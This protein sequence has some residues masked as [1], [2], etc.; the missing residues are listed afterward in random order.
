MPNAMT[1]TPPVSATEQ[2]PYPPC[3]QETPL[4]AFQ[5]WGINAVRPACCTAHLKELLFFIDELFTQ[6]GIFHW[7]DFGTLLGAVRDES[8]IAWD[9]DVDLCF[10][11]QDIPV[12]LQLETA[13]SQRGYQLV[14]DPTYP[15]L[16]RLNYSPINQI[17]VDLWAYHNEQGIMKLEFAQRTERWYF[18][19]HYLAQLEMVTLYGR[20]F[21][22]P[23]PVHS[24]LREHRYGATYLLPLRYSHFAHLLTPAELTPFVVKLLHEWNNYEGQLQAYQSEATAREPTDQ[25]TV[26][27][28]RVM[29]VLQIGQRFV[30][31]PNKLA[32]ALKAYYI[33]GDQRRK[34]FAHLLWRYS[35]WMGQ[36][37]RLAEQSG[38]H[39][40]QAG[41]IS[42][43]AYL[44][45]CEIAEQKRRLANL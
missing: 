41:E 38:Q 45:L 28:N 6:Q 22:A 20:H 25:P 11:M 44:L 40:E 37:S 29:R 16:F 32:Y 17:H 2:S 13:I 36:P 4:C 1:V 43:V 21:P 12:L 30:R 23:S 14:C 24:F 10:L 8:L 34:W 18:P 31:Q 26:T 7:I 39:V 19:A 5:E 35:V 9:P 33:N 42:P 15:T 3:N 27:Y